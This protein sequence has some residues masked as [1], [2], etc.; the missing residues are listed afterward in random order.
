[1]FLLEE[2]YKAFYE[3]VVRHFKDIGIWS[4]IIQRFPPKAIE[5]GVKQIYDRFIER[6]ED[7][8][9]LDWVT[10]FEL[11]SDHSAIDEFLGELES[12]GLIPKKLG[13]SVDEEPQSLTDLLEKLGMDLPTPEDPYYDARMEEM[14][15]N[16][17]QRLL[18]AEKMAGKIKVKV[19]GK[20]RV[21]NASRVYR[22]VEEL[23]RKVRDL[24][25][26]LEKAETRTAEPIKLRLLQPYGIYRPGNVIETRDMNLAL[27]LINKKIAE[28]VGVS[29]EEKPVVAKSVSMVTVQFVQRV[30]TFR[31]Q[32]GQFYGPFSVGQV[33]SV[34]EGDA[35]TL[36]KHTVAQP[37][38]IIPTSTPTVIPTLPLG[39][40]A[41]HKQANE[42]WET[43][44]QAILGYDPAK[45]Q[46]TLKQ[47]KAIRIQLLK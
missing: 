34:P 25:L 16:L 20:T 12:R 15:G 41:L 18:E 39:K 5:S 37:W 7:P 47:L 35:A 38:S 19:A 9:E 23:N 31:G 21:W 46:A 27:D 1:V 29:P 44:K 4:T 36:I 30:D 3:R 8:E 24:E 22:F 26:A 45:A 32:D 13:V 42:L 17:A 43:Y 33:A 40:G 10:A 14:A 11:L 2:P 28:R 6:M